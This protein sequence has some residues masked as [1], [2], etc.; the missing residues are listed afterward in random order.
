MAFN[1][2]KPTDKEII[3]TIIYLNFG[4]HG[5][6][7]TSLAFSAKNPIMLDFDNAGYRARE[8]K[9]DRINITD[10]QKD[11]VDNYKDF[12]TFFEGYDTI[13]I[14]TPDAALEKLGAYIINKDSK[15]AQQKWKLQ[16]Y[17]VL[18]DD[19][20]RFLAVLR[21]LGKDIVM[22]AHAK[23]KEENNCTY[24]KPQITGGAN[25]FIMRK[26]DYISFHSIKNNK[27]TIDFRPTDEHEGKSDAKYG[28]IEIPDLN[29]SPNFLA[30]LMIGMKESMGE[31]ANS[32]NEVL[33]EIAGL[34]SVLAEVKDVKGLNAI[35]DM[36]RDKQ[37]PIKVPIWKLTQEKAFEIGMEY[38][39]KTSEFVK[40]GKDFDKVGE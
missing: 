8:F 19:F 2:I 6:G 33:D 16:F 12:D 32:H 35:I 7:K 27:R 15:Y 29:K 4:K 3:T 14:D 21:S 34:K 11:I 24:S 10:W 17:G 5:V 25:D 18:K 38:D 13:I 31:I 1:I 36:I 40:I 39:K 20:L 26:A 23:E 22:C 37:K 28:I 9:K 30:E